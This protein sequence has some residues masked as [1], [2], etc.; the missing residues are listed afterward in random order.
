M[1]GTELAQTAGFIAKAFKDDPQGY[2]RGVLGFEPDPWQVYVLGSVRDNRRTSVRSGHGVG[3]TRLAASVIHWFI[4]TRSFPRIRCTSNT[5]KQIMSV[6][7]TELAKIHREAKNKDLF[8]WTKT[9]FYL[10]P[11]P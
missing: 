11:S 6:L 3:K 2:C 7:W 9:K 10:K 4:S 1:N 5:E 8:E